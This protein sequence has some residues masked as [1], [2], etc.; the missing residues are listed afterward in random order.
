MN[1][2][3]DEEL[4]QR[5]AA[6]AQWVASRGAEGRRLVGPLDL[7]GVALAGADLRGAD[8][9]GSV[10]TG[11]RVGGADLRPA[12]TEAGRVVTTLRGARCER[13]DFQEAQ[14]DGADLSRCNLRRALFSDDAALELEQISGAALTGATLPRSLD[15]S[16]PFD[17]ADE[18][19]RTTRSLLLSMLAVCAYTVVA[20]ASMRD[21]QL[22]SPKAAFRLP[23]IELHIAARPFFAWSALLVTVVFV[24]LQLTVRRVWE[25]YVLLPSVLPDGTPRSR[26]AN[27]WLLVVAPEPHHAV[28]RGRVQSVA[29]MLVLWGIP[30]LTLLYVWGRYLPRHD[31][32]LTALQALCLAVVVA[33]AASSFRLWRR[34]LADPAS[35]D[36]PSARWVVR[37]V[38]TA[39]VT[40]AAVGGASLAAHDPA[41]PAAWLMHALGLRASADLDGESLTPDVGSNEFQID[42]VTGRALLGLAGVDLRL[43]S[44]DDATA[45]RVDFRGADLRGASFR[46][47]DLRGALF[48]GATRFAGCDLTGADLRYARL[49][50]VDLRE[51]RLDETTRLEDSVL[52]GA[53][54]RGLDL[55]RVALNRADLSA[56]D[57]RGAMLFLTVLY[58]AELRD[59]DLTDAD[60]SSALL[61]QARLDNATLSNVRGADV[62]MSGASLVG[63]RAHDAVLKG[64]ELSNADLQGAMLRGANLSRAWLD[65]AM[66]EGADLTN[67]DLSGADARGSFF[68][69]QTTLT[70]AI[71]EGLRLNAEGIAWLLD[72]VDRASLDVVGADGDAQR[73]EAIAAA[74]EGREPPRAPEQTDPCEGLAADE[75]LLCEF[76]GGQR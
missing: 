31:A 46:G 45:V 41:A 20:L 24:Y 49:P 43:A 25:R 22:F 40:F 15:L 47:A 72:G 38:A 37:W 30:L 27:P 5:L 62:R 13:A 54:L 32:W 69:R 16:R 73:A 18:S 28:D 61:A 60:I 2:L 66:L 23:I 59:A 36:R 55:S 48:D 9:S 44:F 1:A 53:D 8:L 3:R 29:G 67:A 68:D 11:A 4:S 19:T 63:V 64:A 42:D 57:L 6:H 35:A 14:L 71:T 26:A 74:F 50:G 65:G 76:E 12:E 34:L 7:F 56:A 58:E 33:S 51:V 10:L 52:T 21:V 75:R 17:A 39:G 70:G